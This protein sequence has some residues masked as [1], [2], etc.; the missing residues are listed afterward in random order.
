[1]LAQVEDCELPKD[2]IG[3]PIGDRALAR[4]FIEEAL[5]RACRNVPS[6]VV[7]YDNLQVKGLIRYVYVEK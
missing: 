5:N 7:K 1:V 3:Q 4:P 6:W 2:F